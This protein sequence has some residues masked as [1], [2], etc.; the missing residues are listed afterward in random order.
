MTPNS[1]FSNHIYPD[2]RMENNDVIEVFEGDPAVLFGS[3]IPNISED[4]EIEQANENVQAKWKMELESRASRQNGALQDNHETINRLQT[5]YDNMRTAYERMRRS[6]H[7]NG[8]YR[9]NE[10]LRN[11]NATL[12]Y[13]IERLRV[14]AP[15]HGLPMIPFYRP[16][17]ND[18]TMIDTP[19][20]HHLSHHSHYSGSD[21]ASL[22]EKATLVDYPDSDD[23]KHNIG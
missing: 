4:L 3:D 7:P 8:L 13:E 10:H 15:A 14:N 17:P 1:F 6:D 11:D 18:H 9:E 23:E 19:T 5:G 21:F 2:K 12:R 20:A 16:S 22:D